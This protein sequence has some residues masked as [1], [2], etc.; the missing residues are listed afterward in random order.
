MSK[1]ERIAGV[2]ND[3][4]A[5]RRDGERQL[6]EEIGI[7]YSDSFADVRVRIEESMVR[8]IDDPAGYDV[9]SIDGGVEHPFS[10]QWIRIG[11]QN[12]EKLQVQLRAIDSELRLE[13][14]NTWSFAV[15]V[16]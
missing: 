12:Q 10:G 5:E 7:R 4:L 14:I 9:L 6:C 11:E 16:D 8:V 13:N 15:R 2:F 3:F 1:L